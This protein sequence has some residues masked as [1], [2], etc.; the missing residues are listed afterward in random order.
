MLTGDVWVKHG[1][2]VADATIYLLSSFGRTPQNPQEKISSDY[3]ACELLYYI[4]GL[5]PS[6]F[7]GVLPDEYYSHFCRLVWAIRIIHQQSIYQDQLNLV[8]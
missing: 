3:K 4:Y 2:A 6:V 5:G 8:H 1:K 7:Y